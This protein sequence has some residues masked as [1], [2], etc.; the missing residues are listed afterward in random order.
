MR[1]YSFKRG[2]KPTNERLEEMI[3]KQFGEFTKD[4]DV[5]VV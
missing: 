2:F 1:E 3:K 5:Y 4:G